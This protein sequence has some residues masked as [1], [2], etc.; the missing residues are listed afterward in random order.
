MIVSRT[1]P[2]CSSS[3]TKSVFAVLTAATLLLGGSASAMSVNTPVV[4]MKN[5]YKMAGS[6][7]Y[8]T[9]SQASTLLNQ[10]RNA[11][12]LPYLVET[13]E[14]N[15]VNVIGL[16]H[17]GN[18]YL[19]LAK[20]SDIPAQRAVYLEQSEQAFERVLD[21]NSDLTLTHFKLG[22]I[23]LMR[24]D[25]EAAKKYYQMGLEVEP[26]NAALVFNLA[27]VYDQSNDK[28]NAIAWY[29]K[30]I[31]I[32]PKFTYAYNNLG[33]L[34]EESGDTEQAEHYY[35]QALKRDKSYNLARLNLGNL[36]ATGARYAEARKLFEEASAI[37]P[38]NEWVYYYSGNL[39]LRMNDY[40]H[41]VE[42]YNK[43]IELNPEHATTYYLL[44]VSLS[45]AKRMD[46]AMQA[47]L[48]YVALDPNGQYSQEMKSLIMTVKLSHGGIFL[49]PESAAAMLHQKD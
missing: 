48:H 45:K 16:F 1:V 37:E 49:T 6:S 42:S 29:K 3:I 40:D 44:A 14:R 34:Y 36:Y 43:A 15:P 2:E 7:E 38:S 23:A 27:R 9:L 33:L 32:D 4:P 13:V 31:A 22:K 19:E 30:T 35:K 25:T 26:N 28:D 20:Q 41:A 21:L 5:A 46:E 39:Y 47:S 24:G 18:A 17:L 8:Y 10:D 11:Q 12:A